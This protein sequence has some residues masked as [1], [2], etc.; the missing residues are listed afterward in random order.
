MATST[1]KYICRLYTDD[2]LFVIST[3]TF[4]VKMNGRVPLLL[5]AKEAMLVKLRGNQKL[6]RANLKIDSLER[7]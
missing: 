6:V 3:G 4:K 1:K 7:I 5:T 2:T